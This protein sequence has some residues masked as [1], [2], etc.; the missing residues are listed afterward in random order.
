VKNEADLDVV[1]FLNDFRDMNHYL[2]DLEDV[3]TKLGQMINASS[4]LAEVE[5]KTKYSLKIKMK[6]AGDGL[7]V[8]VLPAFDNVKH[9]SEFQKKIL[10]VHLSVSNCHPYYTVGLLLIYYFKNSM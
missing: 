4:L 6:T 10:L 9:T 3:L 2:K 5:Y 8:D 1:V 7:G